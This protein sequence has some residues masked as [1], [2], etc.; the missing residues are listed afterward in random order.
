MK[1]KRGRAARFLRD[2]QKSRWSQTWGS[3]VRGRQHCIQP[4]PLFSRICIPK[5]RRYHRPIVRF[6]RFWC[7][8]F[9]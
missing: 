7:D 1:I 8:V 6:P 2:A 4:I 3:P 9:P 5:Y